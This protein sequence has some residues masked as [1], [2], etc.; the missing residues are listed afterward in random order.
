[1][2]SAEAKPSTDTSEAYERGTEAP[3]ALQVVSE[4]ATTSVTPSGVEVRYTS[5][6]KRM[7]EVRWA[8]KC[9]RGECHYAGKCPCIDNDWVECPSVTTVLGCLDKPGL[10]WWGMKVGIEG[11]LELVKGGHVRSREL[12]AGGREPV[13]AAG[14]RY[15]PATQENVVP[16][17]TE[18]K[19]TVNHVR[20]K[21]GD[22]GQAVHDAFET[23]AKTGH[24]PDPTIYP[25]SETGYVAGLVAFLIDVD[26][27]PL[28]AEVMVGS[29]EHGFAGRYDIRL[30]IT[31]ECDVVFHRTPK[32]GPQ[33][34]RL[35]PGVILADLKSSKDVYMESH[36]RQ[37]EAY[38]LASVE[39]GYEPT[40]AR[41]ILNVNA[42]GTYKFVRS[43]CTADD[44]LN[45]LRVYQDNL[46]IKGAK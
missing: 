13:V 42:D 34:A 1:V 16:L 28:E 31:K 12:V 15:I 9:I 18:N 19:L 40:T 45:V 3:V 6:P 22:R 7:Y 27:E 14:W 20:D 41:G 10:P 44:F 37:L 24:L 33:Y 11:V 25:E 26:P 2:P 21:A 46:R 32:K 43:K 38:E 30:C 17:L 8:K 39:C 29:V 36:G 35:H 23:W 5:K 4:Y